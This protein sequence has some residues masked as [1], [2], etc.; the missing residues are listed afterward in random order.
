MKKFPLLLK[1]FMTFVA[2]LIIIITTT[3]LVFNYSIAN[4]TENEIAKSSM[5]KLDVSK[6][7]SS[8]IVE[9]IVS[10]TFMLSESEFINSDT[11]NI[12]NNMT[13]IDRSSEKMKIMNLMDNLIKVEKAND[14]IN[15][16]YIYLEDAK[17]VLS[18]KYGLHSLDSFKDTQ[19]LDYYNQNKAA[20]K[21]P[22]WISSHMPFN[23][24]RDGNVDAADILVNDHSYVL[25]YV[26]PLT[27]YTT[28]VKGAIIVNLNMSKL[29]RQINGDDLNNQ[30]YIYIVDS[31][32]NIMTHV[33]DSMLGKNLH[34]N[35]E[36]MKIIEGNET[37]GYLIDKSN[38]SR[39]LITFYKSNLYDWIYIGVFQMDSLMAKEKALTVTVLEIMLLVLVIGI[40]FSYII[41]KQIYSPVKKLILDIKSKRGTDIF[42]ENNEVSILSKAFDSILR[43]E[44]QLNS[45]L[46]KHER[47]IR[48]KYIT[49]LLKGNDNNEDKERSTGIL[50]F[51]YPYFL[52]AVS[53]IDRYK[54]FLAAYPK[55]QRYYI[56]TWIL[57]IFEEVLNQQRF[58]CYG[59]LLDNEKIAMIINT[60]EQDYEANLVEI[61]GC[62]ELVSSEVSKIM[63]NTLSISIGS[64]KEREEDIKISMSE[65]M[66]FLKL[67]LVYGHGSIITFQEGRIDER[68]YSYPFALEKHIINN[69]SLGSKE[70]ILS[71]LTE[72]FDNIKDNNEL[73]YDNIVLMLNQLLASAV[74]FLLDSNISISDVFGN[75]VNI[76]RQLLDNETLDDVGIWFARIF[77]RIMEYLKKLKVENKKYID[78]VIDYIHVNYK[79]DIDINALAE[80]VGIS[81]SQL[82]RVFLSETGQNM[83]EYINGLR[84]EEAKRLLRQTNSSIQEI[85]VSLGYNNDRSFNRFFKKYEG[86]TPGEFRKI[87]NN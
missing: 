50:D 2:F 19:W 70:D 83:V 37:K 66:D 28:H 65:A 68:K 44:N 48:E 46:E 33:D 26:Y 72:F 35:P 58:K 63:D 39:Q 85:A 36:I 31:N 69:V 81:Y 20:G 30:G 43:Q 64:V 57:R 4:Y 14:E 16:I 74:R 52:C 24:T 10:D 77:L 23:Q 87:K 38:N 45:T 60:Q 5:G 15:S 25:T 42:E 71:S 27:E 6:N 79:T 53:V 17:F 9:G 8:K 75:D 18:S 1:T 47:D 3:F 78:L 41:S 54:D 56:K 22:F 21:G 59:I 7:I 32:A 62:F 82:R 34:D 51:G 12:V 29:S 61:Q 55:E 11:V 76:H 73:S 80:Q 86:I 67:K 13:G 84:I 40:A 49:G